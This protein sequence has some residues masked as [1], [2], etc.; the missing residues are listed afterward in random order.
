MNHWI[1]LILFLYSSFVL[2]TTIAYCDYFP[3]EDRWMISVLDSKA[4][5]WNE[6]DFKIK[7]SFTRKKKVKIQ[8]IFN[9]TYYDYDRQWRSRVI[10]KMNILYPKILQ[11]VY[12][13]G[14]QD[15]LSI[16]EAKLDIEWEIY[17]SSSL[18]GMYKQ[19]KLHWKKGI[20]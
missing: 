11:Q 12:K 4:I 15:L 8:L 19:G 20:Y 16:F 5:I 6:K 10:Q 17:L 18:Y 2:S 7:F 3:H 13:Y 1:K 9:S 14:S